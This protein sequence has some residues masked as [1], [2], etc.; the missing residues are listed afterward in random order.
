[1]VD[2][3]A[4]APVPAKS[5]KAQIMKAAG[6]LFERGAHQEAS[7]EAIAQHVGIRKASLY[8]YFS[9]KDELLGQMQQAMIEPV[10]QAHQ[11]RLDEGILDARGLLLGMVTDLVSLTETHP[12]HMRIY[13]E[14]QHE[15]PDAIRDKIVEQADRYGEM[16]VDVLRRGV[17]EGV[18]RV[19]APNLTALAI[20]GMCHSTYQWYRPGGRRTVGDIAQYFYDTLITGIGASS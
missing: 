7:M 13:V 4:Q 14:R 10:I 9:S 19:A 5:R 16:L 15:L 18:F 20:L 12:G 11:S 2:E 6:D 1:M 8:Y 3:Q 17:A